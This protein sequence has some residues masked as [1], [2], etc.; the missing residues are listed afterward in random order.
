MNIHSLCFW[1]QEVDPTPL[2]ALT[3]FRAFIVHPKTFYVPQELKG[4]RLLPLKKQ[5]FFWCL[6]LVCVFVHACL[7]VAVIL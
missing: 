4:K 1:T 5:Q 7:C 2:H 3:F 6:C